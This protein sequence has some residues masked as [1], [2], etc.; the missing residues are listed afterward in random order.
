MDYIIKAFILFLMCLVLL[1][2]FPV[3]MVS[4]GWQAGKE[5]YEGKKQKW[6]GFN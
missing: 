2:A 3:A 4:L 5:I 6:W 1:V